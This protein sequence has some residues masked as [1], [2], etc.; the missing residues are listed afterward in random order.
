MKRREAVNKELSLLNLVSTNNELSQRE[1]ARLMDVSLGTVNNMIQ[2]FEGDKIISVRKLSPRKVFYSL[3]SK[4]RA[5]QNNLYV[6]HISS[7]FDTIA[8]VRQKVKLNIFRLVDEGK[9]KFFVQ[10][11]TDELL[12]LAKMIFFEINRKQRIEYVV[13]SDI[14]YPDEMFKG[15]SEEEKLSTS[16]VGWS[17]LPEQ[18]YQNMAYVNL[19]S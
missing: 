3:T 9:T 15:L 10:G 8:T 12:R 18:G 13:L 16:L 17:T 14:E 5:Y 11:E 2:T 6:E 1:L 4:G 19:L 7:C